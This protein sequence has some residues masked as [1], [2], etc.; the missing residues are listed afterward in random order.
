MID[1]SK[2]KKIIGIS[3]GYRK[4]FI[5][6]EFNC[7]VRLMQSPKTSSPHFTPNIKII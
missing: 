1:E 2:G 7:K 5:F 4:L 3:G 6:E